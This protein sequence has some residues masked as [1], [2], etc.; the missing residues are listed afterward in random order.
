MDP[1]Q[2]NALFL[3]STRIHS[4]KGISI[5]STVFAGLTIVTD[6]QTDRLADHAS[7]SLSIARI[8]AVV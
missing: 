7:P 4:L 1:M 5:G 8:Y 2:S 6:R 3:G